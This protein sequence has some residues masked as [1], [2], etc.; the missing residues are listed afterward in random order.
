M[1]AG[2]DLRAFERDLARLE[3]PLILVAGADDG[4]VPASNAF[5]VRA[6]VPHARVVT[7]K[8]LGHLAHEEAPAL[9]RE[10]VDGALQESACA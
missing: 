6:K 3:T 10:I 4:M 8:G 9:I 1:M 5:A 2:W 7:L